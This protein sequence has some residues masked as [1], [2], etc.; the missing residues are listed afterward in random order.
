MLAWR[1]R[2]RQVTKFDND[3]PAAN[4][5]FGP[6]CTQRCSD[7][8]IHLTF[9]GCH[10]PSSRKVLLG[11]EWSRYRSRLRRSRE[12][13]RS[14]AVS[15]SIHGVHVE[16]GQYAAAGHGARF[17]TIHGAT[18]EVGRW[19]RVRS[20]RGANRVARGPRHAHRLLVRC[21]PFQPLRDCATAWRLRIAF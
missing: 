3:G 15:P 9:Q 20:A 13:P 5:A 2:A 14:W 19:A 11:T 10:S 17:A 1:R 16:D 18:A 21:G 6:A 4:A 12:P 7:A 8:V